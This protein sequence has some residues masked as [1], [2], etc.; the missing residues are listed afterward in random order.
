MTVALDADD[1]LVGAA[2]ALS[3]LGVWA[4]LEHR[5][6]TD[7]RRRWAA[8]VATM[9]AA[10]V[11]AVLVEDVL[12]REQDQ[13][14]LSLDARA[15]ASVRTLGRGP[16][17]AA[18]SLVSRLTGEGLVGVVVGTAVAFVA[19]RRRRDAAVLIAGTLS[20]WALASALK[21]AF[22]VTRP[23]AHKVFWVISGYG[24]PS[25]HVV[26]TLVTTGL[27][28]WLLGRD[29]SRAS[30]LAFY[31]AAAAL[32][33]LAGAARIVVD[34]HWLSDVVAGLA[35]GILWLNVVV[36]LAAPRLTARSLAFTRGASR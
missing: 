7:V 17:I 24:F 1:V 22:G 34:A 13:V 32:T 8:I 31:G 9:L 6:L 19:M 15:R 18:A 26:V 20:A 11:L 23:H 16:A 4:T 5:A 33:V 36:L 14:V 25:A 35:V 12:N 27:L 30:R 2:A 3:V 29:V 28:A 10:M 21:L